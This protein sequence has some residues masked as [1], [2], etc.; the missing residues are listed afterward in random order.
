M[1]ERQSMTAN[2][3]AIAKRPARRAPMER[4]SRSY[5]HVDT[6]LEGDFKGAKHKTRQ[7]TVLAIED[8]Q[9]ALANLPEDAQT[10]PWTVRR[11]NL[12]VQG[13]RLPRVKG[14]VLEVGPVHLEIT[15]QTHPCKRMDEAYSGLLKALAPN[16]RGGVTC[17]VLKGGRI[18]LGDQVSIISSP[19]EPPPRRLPG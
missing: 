9:A 3:L 4:V 14:A 1:P 6:G 18:A 19:P 11:A 16:W 2:L 12:L 5:I 8:W 7:I 13:L 10:L 15:G 17:R